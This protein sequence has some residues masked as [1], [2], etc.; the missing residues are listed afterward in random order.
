MGITKFTNKRYLTYVIITLT[1]IVLPFI[2]INGNHLLLLSFEM[3]KFHLLG[4]VFDIQELYLMPFILIILFVGIFLLTSMFGRIWCGWMCPQTIFRVIYRDLIE[5][6]LLRLRKSIYSKQQE[7]SLSRT[8]NKIKQTIA[9][10]IWIVLSLVI[11]SNFL[12][13][14]IPYDIF[15]DYIRDISNHKILLSFLLFITLFLIL[16]V[17]L[18]RKIFVSI[19]VHIPEYSQYYMIT[20]PKALFMILIEVL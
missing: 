18:L 15:F 2:T 14:F 20:I 9:I 7:V 13:Y 1:V 6:K 12:L 3:G 8:I 17:I 19:C 16:D 4:V 5:T 10:V 11:S